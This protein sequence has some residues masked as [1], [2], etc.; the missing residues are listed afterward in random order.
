MNKIL[1]GGCL[2]GKVKFLIKD[3]FKAFFQCHCKQCQQLTGSAYSSNIFTEPSNI[4]WVCGEDDVSA[5]EHPSKEISKSFCNVCGAGLPYINK[6]K[7]S[8][9]VPAGSLNDM[10]DIQP[11]ANI[12]TAEEACWFKSGLKAQR[13]SG[14]K[15]ED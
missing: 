8:L 15:N 3:E 5:Y 2:C 6:T 9:V 11:Q 13:F 14:F 7:T 4:E 10:P 12:F 1:S